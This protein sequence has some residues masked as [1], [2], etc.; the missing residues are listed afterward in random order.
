MEF[1]KGCKPELKSAPVADYMKIRQYVVSMAE[2]G[3]SGAAMLPSMNELARSF[4]VTRM[5][6]HKALK[7]L[8][9]DQYLIVRKGIGTYI[10][11]AKAKRYLTEG[12]R[13]CIGLV[14][15]TASTA[16]TTATTGPC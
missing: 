4:G 3:S 16:S 10:N 12:E 13:L 7:D 8:I 15:G 9:R 6:V 2:R 14:V 11:P 1:P 5:T